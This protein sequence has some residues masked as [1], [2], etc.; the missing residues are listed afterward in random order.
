MNKCELCGEKQA[1]IILEH[2]GLVLKLCEECFKS[3][4]GGEEI[5]W[6]Y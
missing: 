5:E 3:E 1:K 4:Y 6:I 2:D